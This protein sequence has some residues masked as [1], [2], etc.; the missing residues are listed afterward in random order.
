MS[1]VDR[2][3][4]GLQAVKDHPATPWIAA[5]LGVSLAAFFAYLIYQEPPADK[6]HMM[7]E[8][9]GIT[10]ALLIVPGVAQSIAAGA[11]AILDVVGPYLPLK[12]GGNGGGG[13][14][15]AAP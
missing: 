4:S 13:G 5:P 7:F 11:K 14:S 8:G 15:N 3:S 6:L 2:V 10:V 12:K 9:G 1:P